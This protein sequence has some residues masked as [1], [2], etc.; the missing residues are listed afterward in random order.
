[1]TATDAHIALVDLGGTQ[2]RVAISDAEGNFITRVAHSTPPEGGQATIDAV[3]RAIRQAIGEGG[4]SVASIAIVAPG[5][6]DPRKGIVIHA[7]NVPKW[8]NIPLSAILRE[9]FSVPVLL[10]ND[11]SL[12]AL[13]EQ[14]YGAGQG[15]HDL[16]YLTVSTGIGG[17]V[18]SDDV[19]LIGAHGYAAELGHNSVWA[20]GPRCN[21]GNRGCVETLASGPAIARQAREAI[22]AGRPSLL[23]EMAGGD[24]EAIDSR[25]VAEAARRGD[26]VAANTFKR[27]GYFLGVAITNFLYAFDPTVVVL[28]GGVTKAG[29]LLFDPVTATVQ[30]RAPRAY[31]EHCEIVPAALGEDVGL[32]GAL[33]LYLSGA[34]LS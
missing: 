29:P 2:I 7:P 13:G 26:T 10:G 31:W 14:W 33:A 27:A 32:R 23:T 12:A 21:C 11:A 24:L 3:K 9:E 16:I 18:I 15:H 5:P 6:L 17:G 19:L 20:D 34:G 1:M 22:R 4:R 30:S 28:G 8:R 25:L